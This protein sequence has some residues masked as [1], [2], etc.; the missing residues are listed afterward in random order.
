[1]PCPILQ[2]RDSHQFRPQPLVM[3]QLSV[4]LLPNTLNFGML[5]VVKDYRPFSAKRQYWAGIAD[6]CLN[7]TH[8]CHDASYSTSSLL[9]SRAVLSARRDWRRNVVYQRLSS[10]PDSSPDARDRL[11]TRLELSEEVLLGAGK[12]SRQS[13]QRYH[14]PLFVATPGVCVLVA[15]PAEKRSPICF[16]PGVSKVSLQERLSSD[17]RISSTSS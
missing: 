8:P 11:K 1:M 13:V 10:A 2:R 7:C 15:P 6:E 12:L 14:A 9:T 3:L 4:S 16:T 5:L 17:H